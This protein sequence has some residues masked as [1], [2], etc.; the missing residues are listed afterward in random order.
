MG[1]EESRGFQRREGRKRERNKNKIKGF[2]WTRALYFSFD[3][4]KK[5]NARSLIYKNLCVALYTNVYHI[6]FSLVDYMRLALIHNTLSYF[7]NLISNFFNPQTKTQMSPLPL[8]DPESL[9]KDSRRVPP[10]VTEE[11]TEKLHCILPD[12]YFNSLL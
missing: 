4:K 1:G 5:I 9:D 7:R 12:Y 2:W 10:K 11:D 3:V 6:F 8:R